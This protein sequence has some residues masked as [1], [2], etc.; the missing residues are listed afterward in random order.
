MEETTNYEQEL[1]SEL[2]DLGGVVMKGET[3]E[4]ALAAEREIFRQ[5]GLCRRTY[6]FMVEGSFN[7][8]QVAFDPLIA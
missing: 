1:T 4:E 5:F 7:F 8:K 3:L 2:L 6:G